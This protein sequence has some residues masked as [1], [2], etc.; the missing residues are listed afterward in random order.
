[1]TR[2]D[3]LSKNITARA[4]ALVALLFVAALQVEEAGHDF[5]HSADDSVVHCLIQ[6]SGNDVAPPAVASLVLPELGA[7]AREAGPVLAARAGAV[8]PFLSR[9]PPFI[10]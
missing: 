2:S 9:A 6:Q 3:Q 7:H 5:W 1:M 8:V 4:L 10:S